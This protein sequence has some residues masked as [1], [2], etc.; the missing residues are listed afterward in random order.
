MKLT[1]N[2]DRKEFDC[3]DGTKVPAGLMKN[4]ENLAFEL[5]KIRDL[6]ARP[7]KINSG[8]RTE[9]HNNKVGGS[10][11]SYHLTGLA[12]DL[13]PSDMDLKDFYNLILI[14]MKVGYIKKGGLKLYGNFVHYDIRGKI[15]LF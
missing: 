6:I 4:V 11:G 15:V 5:Q 2:F 1:T 3:K 13:V 7:I 8:Y 10:K 14:L 12:V 9:K